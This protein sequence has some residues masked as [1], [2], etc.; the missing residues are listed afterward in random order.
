ME[1]APKRK[2]HHALTND[3]FLRVGESKSGR[4]PFYGIE[5]YLQ[6]GWQF[7]PKAHTNVV[8]R[9]WKILR[10]FKRIRAKVHVRTAE[11]NGVTGVMIY[12]RSKRFGDASLINA[13]AVTKF[14]SQ[15]VITL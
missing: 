2:H 8:V 4:L 6:H 7:Y 9:S 10:K 5:H 1:E 13:L 15:T 14:M 3:Y 12:R 11:M